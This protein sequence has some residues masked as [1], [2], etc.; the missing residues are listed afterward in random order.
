MCDFAVILTVLRL[1]DGLEK[2]NCLLREP[3]DI[4]LGQIW[5]CGIQNFR[6]IARNQSISQFL[7]FVNII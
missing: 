6:L 3:R 2:Y 1:L 7:L 4:L 5:A